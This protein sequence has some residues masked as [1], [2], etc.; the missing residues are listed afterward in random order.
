[1]STDNDD[2][3]KFI[4]ALSLL[5]GGLC[6]VGWQVYEYMRYNI[7]NPISVVTAL[8]WM[9]IKWA[10]NPTDWVGLFNIL[11]IIPLSLTLI[12]MSW[13]VAIS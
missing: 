8:E 12:A 5:I 7:W 1:M 4:A 2:L 3:M 11:K 6:V 10:L 9:N 13:I